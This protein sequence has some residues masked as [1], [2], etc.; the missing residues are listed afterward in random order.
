MGDRFALRTLLQNLLSNAN[1]YTPRGGS[2]EV[3]ISVQSR[4]LNQPETS[5]SRFSKMAEMTKEVILRIEDSG[6]G[7]SEEQR[8]AVFDRFYRVGGDRH[9]SGEQGCGLGLA[10]VRRIVD[11]HHAEI[12]L[13]SSE[14]L[15]GALFQIRFPEWSASQPLTEAQSSTPEAQQW[16]TQSQA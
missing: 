9:Q 13:E 2:I 1:K 11:L 16:T 14:R 3:S 15:H 10:I 7:I 6:P 12:S 5:G 8:E 4:P